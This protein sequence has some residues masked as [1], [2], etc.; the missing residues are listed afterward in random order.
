MQQYF[1]KKPPELEITDARGVGRNVQLA[2]FRGK[3]LL[4][5]FWS[6]TCPPC[7]NESLP[8][9]ARFYEAHAADRDR[10]EIL[11]I[12]LTEFEGA[13]TLAEF[14]PLVA[15][16]VEKVWKGKPLPFPLVLDGEGKMRRRYG[17][18]SFPQTLLVDPEG[19]LVKDGDEAMLAEKLKTP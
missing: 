8:N 2:D 6:L 5:E 11:A 17:I 15:P 4:L 14:D 12:C 13:K 16:I 10:F 18:G 7:I 1:G 19:R 9:L 3:W